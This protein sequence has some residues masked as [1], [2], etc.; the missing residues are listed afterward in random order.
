MII[1]T[2]SQEKLLIE[3]IDS[4]INITDYPFYKIYFIDDSGSGKIGEKIKKK[5]PSIS[6]DAN[7]ENLG[8][9]K[10]YNFGMKKAI[11]EYSPDYLLLLNDDMKIIDKNWLKK[12]IGV[13]ENNPKSG[14]FGCRVVYPDNSL[15]W[16]SENGKT[17]FYKKNGKFGLTEKMK[18]NQKVSDIIG[19]CFLIK[20]KVINKIGFW[21][22][23]FSPA[24]GEE[25]DY[26]FR[27]INMGFELMYVGETEIVHYGSSSTN[28]LDSEWVWF[29]KKR[30]AIR[31][32]WK[33][34]SFL[35]ILFF[36]VIH[37]GSVFSKNNLS[38]SKKLK[39]LLKAY[40][41]NFRKIKEIK[42]FRKIAKKKRNAMRCKNT[43]DTEQLIL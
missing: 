29:L 1:T 39:L 21:D 28:K 34:Y 43:N 6:V 16:I 22:E 37:F 17:K 35:K 4:L 24:Y 20:K 42:L 31:L 14:I 13:S 9:S 41:Y 30:N 11:E 18:K 15:Q 19:C 7:K 25:T 40:L 27:A 12:I 33:H 23:G 8:C 5:F 10:S 26:C 36:T 3:F 38:I 32:E 2:Y